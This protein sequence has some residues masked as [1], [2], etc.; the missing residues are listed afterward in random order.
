MISL[1]CKECRLEHFSS[2]NSIPKIISRNYEK[3]INIAGEL[4][5]ERI[6]LPVPSFALQIDT[7]SEDNRSAGL[8][9]SN[10]NQ[11]TLILK[12]HSA[13]EDFLD[14]YVHMLSHH[15]TQE[16]THSEIYKEFASALSDRL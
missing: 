6:L 16:E 10:T 3:I 12:N 5:T 7:L 8:Y 2:V 11:I 14:T 4:A 1:Y 15:Y 9:N 13:P